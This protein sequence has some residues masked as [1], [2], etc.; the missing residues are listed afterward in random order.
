MKTPDN[1][2]RPLP[3]VAAYLK[4]TE[5]TIDRLAATTDGFMDEVHTWR[6][7]YKAD[8]VALIEANLGNICWIAYVMNNV[9]PGFAGSAFSVT[10]DGC[11]SHDVLCD[12]EDPLRLV[13]LERWRDLDALHEHFRQSGSQSFVAAIDRLSARP[14]KME[15]HPPA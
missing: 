2:V 9:S 15:I 7:T 1:E 4:V 8:L 11:I 6:N 12:P 10:E 5:R 13:F 3:E 14:G